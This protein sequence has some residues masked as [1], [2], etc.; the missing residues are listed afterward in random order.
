MNKEAAPAI[1]AGLRRSSGIVG[2]L[3]IDRTRLAEFAKLPWRFLLIVVAPTL[4]VALYY[5]FIASPLYV[6]TA[7]FVIHT[8]SAS[9]ATAGLGSIMSSVGLSA[10]D[11]QVQAYEVQDY[12]LSRNMTENLARD[13][14]LR[15]ILGRPEGDIGFRYPWPFQ[16]DNIEN[17]FQAYQRFVK[18]DYDLQSGITTLTVQ[19]FRP[20]DAQRLA[21]ALLSRSEDR[22]NELNQRSLADAVAQAQVQVNDAE[23]QVVA[24]QTALT[25][26]RTGSSLIDP[27]KSAAGDL[28][29][30]EQLQSQEAT[31]KAQ[32]AAL[33]ASAPQSPQLAVLDKQIG[34]FAAQALAEQARTAG[35]ANSLAP[36]VARFE[37]LSLDRDLAG[38]Y[39]EAALEGLESARLDAH[40]QQLFVDRIVS[41]TLPDKAIEPQRLYL[42]FLAFV[43]SMVVYALVALVGAGLREHQQR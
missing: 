6:S 22:I 7:K 12:I 36:E 27:E 25:T 40:K 33:A 28:A 34:A 15:A 14:G 18:V 13:N 3:A 30:I 4:L 24:A 2:Q 20:E 29:L 42:I 37:S 10:S 39:L 19:A 8:K 9:A 26:Y 11:Q 21:T 38:K 41:P 1:Q 16:K 43:A 35:Q 17:L 23:A 32:R 31:L 5:L